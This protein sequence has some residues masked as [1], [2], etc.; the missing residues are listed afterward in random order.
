MNTIF[1]AYSKLCTTLT[2]FLEPVAL[3]FLRLM[4][5]KVFL[6]SGLTKWNGFLDF[7]EEKYD[8]FLYEFFCPEEPRPGALLLCNPETLDYEQGSFTVS[9]IEM[10]AYM[11]GVMEILL[12]ILLILG[13]FT[14]LGAIGLLGMTFFIQ[15]AVFPTWDHWWNPAAWW[16]VVLF[17]IIAKGP[18]LLSIDRL[19]KIEKR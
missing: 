8:L 19:L 13:L 7:N 16:S 3:L 15:L 6:Q 14:R 17:S 9:M 18:G 11:A 4:A 5:A 10:L 12:P 2:T 1:N